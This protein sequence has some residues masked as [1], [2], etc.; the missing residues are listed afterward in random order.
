MTIFAVIWNGPTW[1]KEKKKETKEKEMQME[2]QNKTERWD[3]DTMGTRRR[4]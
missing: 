3:Q 1:I 2:A 4:D